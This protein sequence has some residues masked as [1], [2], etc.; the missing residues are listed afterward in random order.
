VGWWSVTDAVELPAVLEVEFETTGKPPTS[1]EQT[2][3]LRTD[4]GR[5]IGWNESIKTTVELDS[6]KRAAH[7]FEMDCE[8]L[9]NKHRMYQPIRDGQ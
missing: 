8:D 2:S 1:N 6:S 7:E 5:K 9:W 3:Q 4:Q